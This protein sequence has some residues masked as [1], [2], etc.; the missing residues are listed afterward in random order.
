MIFSFPCIDVTIYIIYLLPEFDEERFF[1]VR[2]YF[3]RTVSP[4]KTCEVGTYI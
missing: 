3:I 2:F 4:D 1:I